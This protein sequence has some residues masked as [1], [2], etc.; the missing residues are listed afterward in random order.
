[1]TV[2]AFHDPTDR[3]LTQ[4]ARYINRAL[5]RS[6]AQG[7]FTRAERLLLAIEM[8]GAPAFADEAPSLVPKGVHR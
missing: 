8:L 3:D 4:A 5:Q 2:S 7:K 6:R 1:M